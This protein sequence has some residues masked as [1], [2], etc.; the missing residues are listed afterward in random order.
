MT[1]S[2]VFMRGD[3]FDFSN[4]TVSYFI[5]GRSSSVGPYYYWSANNDTD[6]PLIAMMPV[7]IKIPDSSA[8]VKFAF[9]HVRDNV[10]TIMG[11]IG[12]SGTPANIVEGVGAIVMSKPDSE[13]PVVS[14]VL[15]PDKSS[16]VGISGVYPGIWYDVNILNNAS[17]MWT[18]YSCADLS[19]KPCTGDVKQIPSTTSAMQIMIIPTNNSTGATQIGLPNAGPYNT[20]AW[21]RDTSGDNTC[22]NTSDVDLPLTWFQSWSTGKGNPPTAGCDTESGYVDGSAANCYFTSLDACKAGLRYKMCNGG[23]TCGTCMGVCPAEADGTI[24]VCVYTGSSLTAGGTTLSCKK[25]V[26]PMQ[27]FWAKYKL[28]VIIGIVVGVLLLIAAV[29]IIHV[30]FRKNKYPSYDTQSDGYTN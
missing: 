13:V 24:P 29:W 6:G 1:T 26:T 17:V 4:S 27:T 19:Q 5:V 10:Y 3:P 20:F 15:T 16:N 12:D 7:S 22:M 25:A 30:I 9:T 18:V 8:Q 14:L 11:D 21:M 28:Y 2:S 23:E